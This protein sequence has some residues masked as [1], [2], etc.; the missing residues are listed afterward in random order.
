MPEI[1][2]EVSPDLKKLFDLEPCEAIRLP[3]AQKLTVRLP[4][5]GQIQAFPDVSKGV[6]NDCSMTLNLMLQI[7]PFLA[8]T[9]CLFKVLAL[10][11][12]LIDVVK[13]LG[14]PP[15]SIKLENAIPKFIK[16]AAALEPC[17]AFQL[18]VPSFIRDLLCLII[19]VLNCLLGQS[20]SLLAIMSGITLQLSTAE[21][22]GNTALVDALTCAKENAELQGQHLTKAI[23]SIGV[24]LKLVEPLMGIVGVGP[25]QLPTNGGQ[26]D[27]QGL[28]QLVKTIQGFKGTLQIAADT[29]GGCE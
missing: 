10:I 3:S 21:A 14:P 6:P 2:I 22:E 28:Q 4:V 23:E 17:I 11:D 9:A 16:A 26:S 25:F 15:N 12:P 27:I 7:A 5:G 29:L 13:A 24:I 8:S 19:K 1:D 20:K 18:G